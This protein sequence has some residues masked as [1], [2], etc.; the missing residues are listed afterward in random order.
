[1]NNQPSKPKQ[2]QQN[3]GTNPHIK[4]LARAVVALAEI[5]VRHQRRVAALRARRP[6]L[7]AGWCLDWPGYGLNGEPIVAFVQSQY[8][9]KLSPEAELEA[10]AYPGTK[11]WQ[12]SLN[13]KPI[14]GC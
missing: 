13:D 8:I 12:L 6:D 7:E 5:Q 14:P 2:N 9:F 1:M 3:N 10:L 4:Q 11:R